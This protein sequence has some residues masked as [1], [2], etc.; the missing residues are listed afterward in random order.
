MTEAEKILWDGYLRRLKPKFC[1]QRPID[2][3]IVDFY[4]AEANLIVEI[5]GEEHFTAD[6][7]GRDAERTAMLEEYGLRICRFTNSEVKN[8]FEWVC[9]A[10][11]KLLKAE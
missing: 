8:K 7:K 9:N 10:I 3:F 11:E 2:H 1:R 4:C 5:D 6:G